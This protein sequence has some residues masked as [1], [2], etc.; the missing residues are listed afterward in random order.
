[1]TDIEVM[2]NYRCAMMEL[3][4]LERQLDRLHGT[5][6]PDGYRSSSFGE[7]LRGTNNHDAAAAQHADALEQ[8][9]ARKRDTLQHI[10]A[11]FEEI[12]SAVQ[13][14]RLRL[15][16]RSYYALGMTDEAIGEEIFMS[17]RRVNQLRNEFLH[18]LAAE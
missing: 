12:M 11:R 4:L 13:T 7:H 5:G 3:D 2:Q 9:L 15:I 8:L 10:A 14:P 16:L 18:S 6:A 17:T 1:M